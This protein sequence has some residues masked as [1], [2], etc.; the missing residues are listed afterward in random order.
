MLSESDNPPALSQ[1]LPT[2][3]PARVASFTGVTVVVWNPGTLSIGKMRQV[4][5]YISLFPDTVVVLPSTRYKLETTI[6]QG[7]AKFFFTGPTPTDKFAGVCI[8]IHT[9]Y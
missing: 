3:T 9:K 7:A 1:H 4:S 6:T 5:K 8:A 2:L